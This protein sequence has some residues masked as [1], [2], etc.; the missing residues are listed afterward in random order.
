MEGAKVVRDLIR[1]DDWMVS[2]DLKAISTDPTRT[3]EVYPVRMERD[4]IRVS[5]SSL[6]P[7]QRSQSVHKVAQASDGPPQ[8]MRNPKPDIPGRHATEQSAIIFCTFS[9]GSVSV[10]WV[11]SIMNPR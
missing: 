5:M 4:D 11:A 9:S 1:K 7:E 3:L 10:I 6:W 2:I 8:K